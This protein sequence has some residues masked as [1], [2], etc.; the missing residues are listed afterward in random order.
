ME[1][2]GML[3]ALKIKTLLFIGL[4]AFGGATADD[5][6]G[7]AG[8]TVRQALK[9]GA[10]SSVYAEGK[11]FAEEMQRKSSEEIF[12][13]VEKLKVQLQKTPIGEG[14]GCRGCKSEVSPTVAQDS[15]L[16]NGILVFVSFSVPEAALKVLSHQAKKY[17]AKLILRGVVDGSFRRTAELMRKIAVDDDMFVHPELFKKYGIERVPTFVKVKNGEE[18][19][20]LGGNVD[21]EFAS[22]KLGGKDHA[23]H[24]IK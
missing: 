12:R 19:D 20:R 11:A 4:F 18:V 15:D 21:L 14:S 13:E 8:E 10:E 7:E 5:C 24:D 3:S 1:K 23:K 16:E 22:F 6:P 2:T 17:G 9:V